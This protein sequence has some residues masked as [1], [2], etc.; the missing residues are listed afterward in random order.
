[1][2]MVMIS[3]LHINDSTESYLKKVYH[4]IDRMIEA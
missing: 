3:D 1:M 2:K 4:R